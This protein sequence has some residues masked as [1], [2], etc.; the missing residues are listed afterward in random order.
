LSELSELNGENLAALF[1]AL[2]L[3]LSSQRAELRKIT[4]ALHARIP[5]ITAALEATE[6]VLRE[7]AARTQNAPP[8]AH[9]AEFIGKPD[10]E[11]QLNLLMRR[12]PQ[13][14]DEWIRNRQRNIDHLA[15]RG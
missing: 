2:R 12:N 6:D 5:E 9:D 7:L 3:Q 8:A 1:R 14:L 11:H 4:S 15:K 10:F 13:L